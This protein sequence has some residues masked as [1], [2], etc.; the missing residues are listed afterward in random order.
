MPPAWLRIGEAF[1]TKK[2]LERDEDFG[3]TD[4]IGR[5]SMIYT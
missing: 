4:V 1:G 2:G 5:V 3:G